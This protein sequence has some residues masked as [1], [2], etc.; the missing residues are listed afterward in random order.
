VKKLSFGSTAISR[1]R[2]R[3]ADIEQDRA[4]IKALIDATRIQAL[5]QAG[6]QIS[7]EAGDVRV[8]VHPEMVEAYADGILRTGFG[9]QKHLHKSADEVMDEARPATRRDLAEAI[10][11]IENL[12]NAAGLVSR[13]GAA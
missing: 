1:G 7:R 9:D 6:F 13:K 12:L 11:R 5:R 3:R 4:K 10:E 8:T 2:P